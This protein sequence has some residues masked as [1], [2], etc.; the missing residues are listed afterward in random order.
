MKPNSLTSL[1][2]RAFAFARETIWNHLSIWPCPDRPHAQEVVKPVAN[3]VTGESCR[4]VNKAAHRLGELRA[5]LPGSST[6]S[7]NQEAPRSVADSTVSGPIV[8]YAFTARRDAL[9][10]YR[11]I[12]AAGDGTDP[13]LEDL[14]EYT[15]ADQGNQASLFADFLMNTDE[16][17]ST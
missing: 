14:S 5:F 3:D 12:N 15:S 10:D 13:A 11:E 8:T 4:D 17:V 1:L 7:R 2:K 6:L 9:T 16:D